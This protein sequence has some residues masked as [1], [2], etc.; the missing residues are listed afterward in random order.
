VTVQPPSRTR[1][2]ICGIRRPED[3]LIAADAGADAVGIV[4]YREA[5]RYV[6]TEAA[7]RIAQALPAFVTSVALFVDAD[8]DEVNA[9]QSQVGTTCVQLHGR[10][11]PAVARQVRSAV[12]KAI[13]VDRGTFERE[14][15]DWRHAI[16]QGGLEHLRGF[17]LETAGAG[18]GGTGQANDWGFIQGVVEKGGFQGLPPVIAAGGLTPETV[19]A[20]VRAIRP[21]A[22]DVSSGVERVKGEKAPDLVEAFVIAVRDADADAT[23]AF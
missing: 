13:R 20:V 3:A 7:R 21:W 9:V 18:V 6:P 17:V 12:I 16:A 8:P 10:E 1:I 23:T 5:F 11:S 14:L 2:K 15:D 4:C 19:G 22:V